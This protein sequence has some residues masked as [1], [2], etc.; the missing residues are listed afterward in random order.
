MSEARRAESN[1]G[2]GR[3]RTSEA[4]GATDLQSVAF[5]RFATSPMFP[6]VSAAKHAPPLTAREPR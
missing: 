4:A 2:E 6:A 5:D 1:G 3:I